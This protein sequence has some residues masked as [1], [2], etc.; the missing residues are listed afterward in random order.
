MKIVSS[1]PVTPVNMH[2]V[3]F[4]DGAIERPKA[5]SGRELLPGVSKAERLHDIPPRLAG[6]V[7]ATRHFAA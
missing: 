1:I 6:V 2:Q 3:G 5:L 4:G 7:A